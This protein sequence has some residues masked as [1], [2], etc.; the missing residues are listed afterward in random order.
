MQSLDGGRKSAHHRLALLF[1]D[2]LMGDICL[3]L[4]FAENAV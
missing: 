3:N 4:E 2:A 1:F